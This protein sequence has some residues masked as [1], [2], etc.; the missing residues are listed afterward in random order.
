MPLKSGGYLV[1]D[2]TEAMTTIDVNT[3]SFLGQRNLEE[4]VY[5]TNLEA[6]QSV[7]RQLRLRNLGGII[8]IDFIDMTD[9]EHK[10]QVLRTLEKSL[11][12]DHAKTTV[13]DFSPLGLVEM[14]R[15]RTT[16]SLERQ[17]CEPCHECGG[18]GSAEDAGDG[19]CYEIFREITRAVRQFDAAKLLVLASPQAWSRRSSTRNRRR[20]RSWRSSS[21]S[22]S[23]SRPTSSTRR[24][25]SMSCC[26]EPMPAMTLPRPTRRKLHRLRLGLEA[27]VAF[28][29]IF[30]RARV[31][32]AGLRC[33]GLVK[34]PETRAR[35]PRGAA[36]PA[37]R[38]RE[39]RGRLAAGRS[40][41]SRCDS[42]QA[43]RRHAVRDRTRRAR[44]RFLR[45]AAPTRRFSEFRIVG[46]AVDVVREPRGAGDRRGSAARAST[47]RPR[48]ALR[49]RQ[50]RASAR[51][52]SRLRDEV[53]GT[54]LALERVDLR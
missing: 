32:S 41:C 9:A 11:A 36:R 31:G 4:T 17:L 15:K 37:G 44:D 7:A 8:I 33:R 16:E 10:R 28:A 38:V 51:R 21:A 52:A 42:R 13:Y 22:R 24:S 1:I 53:R 6:A 2:Q 19:D 14:T 29:V 3:G 43:R 39:R 54:A 25:S 47:R 35:V 23:A 12:R 26:S 20:W 45:V 46:V 34:H 27:F 18:R 50:L 30:V 5:R 40:A 49:A 48:N